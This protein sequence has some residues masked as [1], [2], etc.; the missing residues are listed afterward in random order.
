MQIVTAI[1][2]RSVITGEWMLV[3]AG[4]A[5]VMFGVVL[6]ARPGGGALTLLWLIGSYA[7]VFGVLLVMLAI[8]VRGFASRLAHS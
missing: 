8:K 5:S 6:M 2:L 1:R 4:L 3:L 7:V